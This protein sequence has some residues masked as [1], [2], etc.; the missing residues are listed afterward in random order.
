MQNINDVFEKLASEYPG[1]ITIDSGE[2]VIWVDIL[3]PNTDKSAAIC[4][5][6]DTGYGLYRPED[7]DT[8]D[9][10]AK[11]DLVL[12]IAKDA[13]YLMSAWISEEVANCV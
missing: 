10:G 7:D 2:T 4:W 6:K 13:Y 9:Y 12:D 8:F 3:V 11:P 1:Q 5:V